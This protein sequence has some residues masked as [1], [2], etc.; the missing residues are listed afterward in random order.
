MAKGVRRSVDDRIAA[1]K[2]EV[3]KA[4]IRVKALQTE[5]KELETEKQQMLSVALVEAVEEA[6][7]TL[8]DAIQKIKA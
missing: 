1:K 8:E 3:E 2:A 7:L 5:L 6:G 4:Q